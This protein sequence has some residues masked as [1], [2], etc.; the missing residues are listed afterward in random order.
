MSRKGENI[1]RRKDGRWE[2]RFK[3][4]RN[5]NGS[6]IY[7]SVYG[8]TY[9]EVKAKMEH[10]I[11]NNPVQ[12][13]TASKTFNDVLELWMKTNCVRLKKAT[14]T[15]YLYLIESHISPELGHMKLSQITATTINV[16]L[17]NK[18]EKG[19]LDGKG[20][21]SPAYVK[22][23]MIIISSALKFAANEQLCPP[24]KS[25]I[26]TPVTRKKDI[27]ILNKEEQLK[28]EKYI[29]VNQTST[30]VGIMVALYSGLR[31]GEVCGLAWEDID[32]ANNV[33]H[34]R[35]TIARVKNQPGKVFKTKLIIDSPKTNASTRDIPLLKPLI[36][37][38]LNLKEN[39]L[40]KYVVSDKE[41]F[42]SP[43]TF[44]V[45]FHKALNE[46]GIEDFNFHTLRHTFATR[47]IESGVD[48]KSLS[49][50]LGHSNVSITLNTYVHSSM[51]MKKSQ[52]EKLILMPA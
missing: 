44:E 52:L 12:I 5:E 11:K 24:L 9:K 35:H 8:K 48:V 29:A 39:S 26:N 25:P 22:S 43:R 40:S 49:E 6:L 4:G 38:L 30:T 3:K 13:K 10:L 31:I 36:P 37:L 34:V 45:R 51:N 27:T 18:L 42:I 50:I 41:S 32:F 14:E 23:I 28:L 15:K 20:G 33:I 16:F 7:L 46:S 21:L 1:R 19:R 47:C 2:G 17:Q